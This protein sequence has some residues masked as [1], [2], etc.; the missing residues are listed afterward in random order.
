MDSFS[1]RPS[2]FRLSFAVKLFS[3]AVFVCRVLLFFVSF[4]TFVT[5]VVNAVCCCRCRLQAPAVL[6]V[7]CLF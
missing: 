5:F 6:R 2:V 3:V 1:L 7:L 4:V